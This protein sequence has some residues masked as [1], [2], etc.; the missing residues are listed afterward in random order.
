MEREEGSFKKYE[1]EI[2]LVFL[3]IY[4]ISCSIIM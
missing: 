3:Y 2:C 1:K 4:V